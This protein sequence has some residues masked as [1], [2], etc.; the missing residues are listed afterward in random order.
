MQASPQRE[1]A[2][3]LEEDEEM[4]RENWSVLGSLAGSE[5][6]RGEASLAG[7]LNSFTHLTSYSHMG[8]CGEQ[9]GGGK[10]LFPI[11]TPGRFLV[12]ILW[13]LAGSLGKGKTGFSYHQPALL[14]SRALCVA[15]PTPTDLC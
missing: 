4:K 7:Q 3:H 9:R 6:R 13:T 15:D 1:G 8:R 12:S 11:Y 14:P 10:Q 5:E 2:H